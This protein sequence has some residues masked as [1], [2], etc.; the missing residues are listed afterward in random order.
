[1]RRLLFATV[2]LLALV[3]WTGS[4]SAADMGRPIYKA[5]APVSICLAPRLSYHGLSETP[6]F[7]P[8]MG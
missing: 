3:G 2:G 8:L 6:R 1:M 5:P 4:V 7:L